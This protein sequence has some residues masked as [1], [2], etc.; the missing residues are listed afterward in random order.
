MGPQAVLTPDPSVLWINLEPLYFI[1]M[2]NKGYIEKL[3]G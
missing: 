1:T 3:C 2:E